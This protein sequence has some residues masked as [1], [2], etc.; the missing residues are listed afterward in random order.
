LRQEREKQEKAAKLAQKTA[1]AKKPPPSTEGNAEADAKKAA[2]LAAVERAKAKK[3]GI[4]VQKTWKT[5]RRKP[6]RKL[7]E[8]EK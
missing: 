3:A 6:S 2:I 7:R 8:I 4:H 5:C 1:A